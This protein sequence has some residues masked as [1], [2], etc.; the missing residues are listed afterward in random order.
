MPRG[1][2]P[3]KTPLE[4]FWAHVDPCRTDGCAVWVAS[5]FHNGYGHFDVSGKTVRAHHVL[6]GHPPPNMQ[7]DHLCRNRACVWPD[8]LE[9]VT[10]KENI[11]RGHEARKRAIQ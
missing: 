2:Y 7:T 5:F 3:R 10:A 11:R 4:Y 1:Y 8:H 6:K 9:F